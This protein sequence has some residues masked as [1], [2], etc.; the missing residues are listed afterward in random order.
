VEYC[1]YGAEG[2]LLGAAGPGEQWWRLFFAD[3]D[4]AAGEAAQGLDYAVAELHGLIT[5]RAKP[6]FTDLAYFDFMGNRLDPAAARGARRRLL[7]WIYGGNLGPVYECQQ[8]SSAQPDAS[9][10]DAGKV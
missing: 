9:L 8:S 6:S 2:D 5:I 10:A 4:Q 3:F 1:R 7:N